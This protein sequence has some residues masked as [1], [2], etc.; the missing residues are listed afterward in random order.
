M[1]LHVRNHQALV[2]LSASL[3][4]QR[5]QPSTV[6]EIGRQIE[7]AV[8][9]Y[10]PFRVASAVAGGLLAGLLAKHF[11][12]ITWTTTDKVCYRAGRAVYDYPA[13]PSSHKGGLP[14]CGRAPARAPFFCLY[15]KPQLVLKAS[16]KGLS[17]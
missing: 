3:F 5:S 4:K 12:P 13:K 11:R 9:Q 17:L 8:R 6:D 10:G 14:A 2:L 1:E 16:V 7:Y 15:P